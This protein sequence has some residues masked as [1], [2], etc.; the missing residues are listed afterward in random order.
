MRALAAL[1]LALPA[2]AQTAANVVV[3]VNENSAL[4]RAIGE[5]YARLRDIPETQFCRIKAP[6]DEEISRDVYTQSIER[7]VARCLAQGTLAGSTWFLVTTQGVPLKVAGPSGT[8]QA[9][10]AAV[11]SELT[12]LPLRMRGAAIP[13][14]GPH[15]NPYFG[16][17]ARFDPRHKI[18]LVT[19]LAAYSFE[20][21]AA[22]LNRS[23]HP[24]NRGRVYL[25]LKSSSDDAGNNWLRDALIRLPRGRAVME[26]T[27]KV[28][29]GASDVIGYA[30]WGSNDPNRKNRLTGFT[31]LPGALATEYVSTNGRTFA[32]PPASWTLGTWKDPK[33]WF[34]GAPQS[35]AADYLAEGATGVSGHV[36]EPFLGFTPRPDHLFPAWLSGLTLAESY[37]Q[38]IPALSWM[39]VVIGDPLTRLEP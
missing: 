30:S 24:K 4:S 13:L 37:Y 18:Y 16:A 31:W 1:W 27:T 34:A 23:L 33:T 6:V 22:L 3:V 7:P 29:T 5:R 36:Y 39:N 11:D 14:A 17:R 28:L 20:D 8:V 25:D 26:D 10:A 32:R 35:L 12:L 2:G 9:E 19:R 15:L 38:A 21:V